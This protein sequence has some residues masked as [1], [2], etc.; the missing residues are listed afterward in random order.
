[1]VKTK[2]FFWNITCLKHTKLGLSLMQRMEFH[3]R[4][5]STSSEE[6]KKH[7]EDLER[8]LSNCSQ[9]IGGD[10][11]YKL[12]L[13]SQLFCK[14]FFINFLTDYLQDQLN[15]RNLDVNCLSEQLCSIQLKLAKMENL[16]EEV[17]RL[18]EEMK[19]FDSERSL[20]IQEI[21]DKE[22]VIRYSETQVENLEE[23]ISSMGL[24]YQC[25]IESTKLE[26]IALEQNLIETMKLLKEKTQ[27]NSRMNQLIQ[28]LELRIRDADNVIENLE[29]ENKDL[30]QKF[31]RSDMNTKAFVRTVEEQLHEWLGTKNVQS[32]SK[33][34][35]DVS[36]YGNIL[37][38]LFSKLT[39]PKAS[40]ADLRNKMTEMS[41][42]IDDYELLVRQLKEEL[43]EEKLKANDEAEDLAQ[44]MAELRYQLT[45]RLEEECKRRAS[46]EQISLQRI[47]ELEGQIAKE[48]QKSITPLDLAV[49]KQ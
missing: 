10:I 17:G 38:P 43:R 28:D 36:T 8:E 46:I 13:P 33:L 40:D 12:N 49:R 34:E 41:R 4:T 25:E 18:R 5:L 29:K 45:S 1:M 44:E 19:M 14:S 47:S 20:L 30:K 16:E 31:Q 32:L 23:S 48:R 37:G 24:E 11:L 39:A 27:E 2:S 42:Q 3:V 9:E 22:V 35:K 7:I 15:M 6:D 21:E 26:S